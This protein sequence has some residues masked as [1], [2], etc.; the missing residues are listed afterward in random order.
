MDIKYM[1]IVTGAF[2]LIIESSFI[3]QNVPPWS[4]E[5]E[6]KG[7]VSFVSQLKYTFVLGKR[8]YSHNIHVLYIH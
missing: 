1:D 7:F 6:G 3:G 2:L 8:D 5:G 4:R